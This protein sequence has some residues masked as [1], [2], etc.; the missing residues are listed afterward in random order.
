IASD[1]V[2][3]ADFDADGKTDLAVWRPST[4]VWY[5]WRSTDGGFTI[6]GF[7]LNGDL[8]VQGD[9]DSDGKADIAVFRPSDSVWY[10]DRSRLGFAAVR[11]GIAT[12][13]PVPGDFDGDG[14]TDIAI[15]RDGV[16]Y[17]LRSSD[18]GVTISLFGLAGDV[19]VPAG[20]ISQ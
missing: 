8:P 1:K 15:F 6:Q 20:Y 17:I 11:F 12:D 13:K 16:W 7:G 4:G 19:P 2:A 9:Y 18:G 10:I 14:K 3:P 5:I